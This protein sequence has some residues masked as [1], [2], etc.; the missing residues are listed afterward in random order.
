MLGV[1]EMVGRMA[2]FVV[3]PTPLP[4]GMLFTLAFSIQDLQGNRSGASRARPAF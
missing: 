4:Q 2:R 1:P 3:Q